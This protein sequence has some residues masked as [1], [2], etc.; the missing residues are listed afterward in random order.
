MF[1]TEEFDRLVEQN[2]P[3]AEIEEPTGIKATLQHAK[4]GTPALLDAAFVNESLALPAAQRFW[5]E[6]F[7]E[8][9]GEFL[10]ELRGSGSSALL[11]ANLIS[12]TSAQTKVPENTRRGLGIFASTE[13]GEASMVGMQD[14]TSVQ[15]AQTLDEY[16]PVSYTH[17]TL[18]TTVFV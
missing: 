13:V 6:T 3:N 2:P 7:G 8:D 4:D 15:S 14:P 18:P 9:V 16:G 12:A 11:F 1:G 5:Y 10:P 17:L